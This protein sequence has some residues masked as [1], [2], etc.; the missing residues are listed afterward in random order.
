VHERDLIPPLQ[1][2]PGLLRCLLSRVFAFAQSFLFVC[3]AAQALIAVALYDTL[4]APSSSST[5]VAECF[6]FVA[7]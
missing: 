3:F 2:P 7:L 6:L 1:P 4:I 5:S